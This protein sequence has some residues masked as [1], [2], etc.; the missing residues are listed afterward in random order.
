VAGVAAAGVAAHAAVTG[1]RRAASRK[2]AAEAPL[3]AFGDT[4][5]WLPAPTTR[6]AEPVQAEPAEA[7]PPETGPNDNETTDPSGKAE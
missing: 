5:V 1:V 6:S 7:S 4:R 2:A 3:D